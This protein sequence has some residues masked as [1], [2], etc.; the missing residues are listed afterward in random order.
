MTGTTGIPTPKGRAIAA[1]S[2]ASR[3][4]GAALLRV[5]LL[6]AGLVAAPS[7]ADLPA[8]E[9]MFGQMSANS[10]AI[11]TVHSH[12]TPEQIIH[13][14]EQHART[15]AESGAFEVYG[16]RELTTLGAHTPYHAA[17]RSVTW[18]GVLRLSDEHAAWVAVGP[19]WNGSFI[20]YGTVRAGSEPFIVE[21]F[22]RAAGYIT[23]NWYAQER[24]FHSLV[25][26]A[27][28]AFG[29]AAPFDE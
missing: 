17:Q 8:L 11:A 22:R 9:T 1:S 5:C 16:P 28:D 21:R 14:I 19:G 24:R 25:R 23:G 27:V 4:R 18:L 2:R 20:R 3:F 29:Y 6:A 13:A 7:R 10:M 26:D 12:G 15:F